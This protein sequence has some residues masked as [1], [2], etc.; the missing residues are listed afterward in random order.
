M[1]NMIVCLI[2][3]QI[4]NK[5]KCIIIYLLEYGLSTSINNGRHDY[6]FLR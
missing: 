3:N 5:Q 1:L 2:D 4:K 6:Q